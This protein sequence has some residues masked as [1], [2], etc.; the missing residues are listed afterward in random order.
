MSLF[1]V[2]RELSSGW[3]ISQ[4]NMHKLHLLFFW[5]CYLYIYIYS[6]LAYETQ[7]A[8]YHMEQIQ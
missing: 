6:V 1:L 3:H 2:F 7:S 4:A 5:F 8:Q